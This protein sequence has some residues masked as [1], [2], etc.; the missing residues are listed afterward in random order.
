[1][2]FYMIWGTLGIYNLTLTVCFRNDY[3]LYWVSVIVSIYWL[4][5]VVSFYL[6]IILCISVCCFLS[7]FFCTILWIFV[8]L[9]YCFVLFLF[10]VSCKLPHMAFHVSF[11]YN[12]W[13]GITLLLYTLDLTDLKE[14]SNH[15]EWAPICWVYLLWL[16]GFLLNGC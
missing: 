5:L 12:C 6:V 14:Y 11:D 15:Y 10:T 2:H 13:F 9:F 7:L 4:L 3:S 8:F 1:M 16:E